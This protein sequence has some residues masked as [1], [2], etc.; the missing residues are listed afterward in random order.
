MERGAPG[1]H[2]IRPVGRKLG[3]VQRRSGRPRRRSLQTTEAQMPRR[4]RGRPTRTAAWVRKEAAMGPTRKK[5]KFHGPRG[6]CTEVFFSCGA[7]KAASLNTR[8]R[9]GPLQGA[10]DDMGACHQR[11]GDIS[12]DANEGAFRAN[13]GGLRSET[14]SRVEPGR[15][16]PVLRAQRRKV[17]RHPTSNKRIFPGTCRIMSEH[18]SE[19]ASEAEEAERN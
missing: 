9:R 10:D 11:R 18:S 7:R 15:E 17:Y 4:P 2:D 14:R 3:R 6:P 5:A 8:E 16:G 12:P 13:L 19:G 1:T